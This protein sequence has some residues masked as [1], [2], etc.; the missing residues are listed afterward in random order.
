[1]A[2]ALP[3]LVR[4]LG[5]QIAVGPSTA[6]TYQGRL[7]DNGDSANGRYDITATRFDLDSG[8]SPVAGPRT[9]SAVGVGHGFF[10]VTLDFGA[11]FP[12]ADRWLEIAVRTNG[13]AGFTALTPRQKF[14]ARTVHHQYGLSCSLVLLSYGQSARAESPPPGDLFR[15][16]VS[17]RIHELCA[18]TPTRRPGCPASRAA[19]PPSPR[20]AVP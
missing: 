19:E 16:A 10:T 20:G 2:L 11:N 6:F 15:Q 17:L 18:A 3:A 5:E 9:N 13:G 1:M 8:G 4:L 7:T 14:T 12:G